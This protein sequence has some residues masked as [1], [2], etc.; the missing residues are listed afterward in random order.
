MAR[1][2]VGGIQHETNVFAPYRAEYEVFAQR[3]EWPPLC[4]GGDMLAQVRGMNLPV[5]G[6]IERLEALGHEVVPLLWCSATPSAEVTE[7]AFERIMAMF[8]EDLEAG[9]PLDGVVLDLHGAMVCEHAPDGDGELLRRFRDALGDDVPIT[10]ALDLH[11]NI[12]DQMATQASALEAYRTYPHVDMAATGARAADLLDTLL[13]RGLTRFPAQAMRRPEFLIPPVFGCTLVDPA[14]AIYARLR[15]LIGGD[16]AGLTLACGF[17]LSDVAEAGPALIAYGFDESRVDA[18][19][20]ELLDEIVRRESEFKGRLYSAEEAVSEAL[21]GGDGP[22]ILADSQD[23]PG[24]GGAGDTTEIIRELLAQHAQGALVGVINDAAA[25][26]VAHRA[27][28]GGK[29][30]L[31]L[32]GRSGVSG[33]RPLEAE[34]EV[35]AVA[36]GRFEATGAMLAGASMD[37]GPTAL[38]GIDGVRIVV[39]SKAIQTMDQS[40]FRHLGIEPAQQRIIALKSSVHFRNDFQQIASRIMSVISPGPVMVDLSQVPFGNE[41][42]RRLTRNR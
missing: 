6:A 30:A 22:V 10:A 19:A 1:I 29:I 7:D 4:R 17:P 8:I 31:A 3:D 14:G 12:S 25:A 15:E 42:L 38:L 11:A 24:G 35:L 13:Q 36:D 9:A 28:P 27:G 26:A 20:A 32:G 34:F 16:V 39:A 5:S 41:R 23:N 37:L 2:A 21:R 18:A 33:T 40:M